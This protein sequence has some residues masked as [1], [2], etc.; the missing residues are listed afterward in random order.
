ML[1]TSFNFSAPCSST[2]ISTSPL[3]SVFLTSE[4]S[5]GPRTAATAVFRRGARAPVPV[6]VVTSPDATLKTVC[7]RLLLAFGSG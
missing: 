5:S 4:W 2:S 3:A 6:P 7:R 1:Y